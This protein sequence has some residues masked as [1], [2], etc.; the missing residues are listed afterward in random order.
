MDL[1][2]ILCLMAEE[3]ANMLLEISLLLV[4]NILKYHKYRH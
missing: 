3:E 4:Q 2:I 1:L